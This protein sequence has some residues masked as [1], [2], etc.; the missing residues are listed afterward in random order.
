MR[1][2]L[3]IWVVLIGFQGLFALC[4]RM[5][6]FIDLRQPLEIQMRIN[7]CG[8]QAFMAEHFLNRAQIA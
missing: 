1:E 5:S 6:R 7:L 8:S 2:E 3:L 4:P